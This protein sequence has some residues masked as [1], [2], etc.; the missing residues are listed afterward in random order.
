M[1]AGKT[2][3]IKAMLQQLDAVDEGNSPTF[4]LVNEYHTTLGKVYHFDLYRIED[5]SELWDFGFEEYLS[6]GEWLFIEWPE[7][8]RNYLEQE[9]VL[10]ELKTLTTESRSLK[11]TIKNRV[12]TENS[13]MTD[14]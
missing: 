12:L 7:Q 6:S 13:A 8:I 14:I 10:L 9:T 1:G 3:L 11:L 2:T 4:G 5:P